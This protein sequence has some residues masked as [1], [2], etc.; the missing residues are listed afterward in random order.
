M[1]SSGWS[2]EAI[3][4]NAISTL[5]S[6]PETELPHYSLITYPDGG[7]LTNVS[8]LGKYLNELIKGYSGHGTLLSKSNYQELFKQQL[9]VENFSE[10]NADH[11]YN[12]EF[13]TGIFMGFSGTGNVGH[14]GGDP[15]VT[16][17]LFFNPKD[18]MGRILLVNT[19]IKNKEGVN[20]FYGIFDT[21][22]EFSSKL[23]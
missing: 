11:P 19:N 9:T 18:K 6:N 7:F 14:T 20:T 3:N 5:Y 10:R 2:Y 1:N 15:G 16:A 12:D 22:E 13:N 17:L 4:S 23:K 21:L 8:D